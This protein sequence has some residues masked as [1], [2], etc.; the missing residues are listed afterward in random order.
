MI[1]R[2]IDALIKA[3][4]STTTFIATIVLLGSFSILIIDVVRDK[5]NASDILVLI[6][7]WIGSIVTGYFVIKGSTQNKPPNGT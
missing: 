2:I 4:F 5:F 3:G 6:G 7:S 1:T